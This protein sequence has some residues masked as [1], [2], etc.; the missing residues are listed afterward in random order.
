GFLDAL[1]IRT[2]PNP[3]EKA[4]R[5]W[6]DATT[7]YFTPEAMA[8]I[9]AKGVR[10]LLVDLPSLDPVRDGGVLAAHR[11]FWDM[12]PGSQELPAGDAPKAARESVDRELAAWERLGVEGH[13][14]PDRPWVSFHELFTDHLARLV[15]SHSHEVVAMNTL[16][17]NLHLMLTTFYRPEPKRFR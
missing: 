2:R 10:H 3:P 4:V 15:G 13:F 12:P 16:T 7:P 9:R 11:V 6:E 14:K 17:V 8:V 1:V 5:R